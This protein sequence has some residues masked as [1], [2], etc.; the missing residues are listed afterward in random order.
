MVLRD[1]TE[2]Q[3]ALDAGF[4][5]LIGTETKLIIVGLSLPSIH[6][7]TFFSIALSFFLERRDFFGSSR[8]VTASGPSVMSLH[9]SNPE[10][11][12]A[13]SPMSEVHK[14]SSMQNFD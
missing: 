13:A 3:E 2:R 6:S 8:V 4:S 7:F 1:T 10:S 11:E 14:A 9:S 5:R 12:L